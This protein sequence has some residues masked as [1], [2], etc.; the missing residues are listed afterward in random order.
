MDG[1]GWKLVLDE[2]VN[3]PVSPSLGLH[4]YQGE[5]LNIASHHFKL[6]TDPLVKVCISTL[7]RGAQF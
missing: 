7:W 3:K 6:T 1:G 4:K 5:A 2:E